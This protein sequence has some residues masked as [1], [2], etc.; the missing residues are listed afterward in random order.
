[1]M[2]LL[3]YLTLAVLGIFAFACLAWFV[4]CA[5]DRLCLS[6]ARRFCRRNGWEPS[7]VRCQPAFEQSGVKTEFTLVQV[8]CL[9]AGKQ[10]KLILLLAWPFGIR[11]LLRDEP[12]PASYDAQWPRPCPPP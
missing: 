3:L 7:R 12:Y 8:D 1:M 2:R 5:L 6:H 4:H 9:D 11:T 10:R